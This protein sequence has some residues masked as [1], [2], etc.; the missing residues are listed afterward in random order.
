MESR[1]Q[2]DYS[3]N[4]FIKST[5]KIYSL[6]LFFEIFKQEYDKKECHVLRKLALMN[7]FQETNTKNIENFNCQVLNNQ[8]WH[9]VYQG[10]YTVFTFRCAFLC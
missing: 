9:W 5:E 3:V 4:F 1:R 6:K 8:I 10:R 7:Y 2:R